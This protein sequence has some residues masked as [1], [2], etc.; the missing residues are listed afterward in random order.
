MSIN[1]SLREFENFLTRYGV[2]IEA[3]PNET[4]LAARKLLDLNPQ[5]LKMWQGERALRRFIPT[6]SPVTHALHI[7]S[8]NIALALAAQITE[9]HPH[10]AVRSRL[11]NPILHKIVS[12]IMPMIGHAAQNWMRFWPQKRWSHSLVG[13]AMAS[14]TLLLAGNFV[15]EEQDNLSPFD[16]SMSYFI[17]DYE[18]TYYEA[19]DTLSLFEEPNSAPLPISL[20][21]L[22]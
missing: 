11:P 5:A 14:V 4:Q 17:S 6:L 13:A 18:S 1:L 21:S 16:L 19:N 3:W 8:Q 2:E 9:S 10:P 7:Q 20:I 12:L 22:D 15:Q